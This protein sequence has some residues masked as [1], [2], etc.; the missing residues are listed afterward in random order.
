M[1]DNEVREHISDMFQL[2]KLGLPEK[3]IDVAKDIMFYLYLIE[4][5]FFDFS[6]GDIHKWEAMR[7]LMY[8]FISPEKGD[9]ASLVKL[10]NAKEK[11]K[12]N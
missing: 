5:R 3:F 10:I 6:E 2:G 11:G 9:L 4:K 1:T 7:E 8:N 12:V